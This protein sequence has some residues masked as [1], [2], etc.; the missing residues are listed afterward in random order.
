MDI[1]SELYK[2]PIY[3]GKYAIYESSHDPLKLYIEHESGEGAEFSV[4]KFEEVINK[5]YQE[6]F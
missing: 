6:H 4:D 1:I 2:N 5:F 3:I